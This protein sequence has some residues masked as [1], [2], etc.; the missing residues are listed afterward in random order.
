MLQSFPEDYEFVPED[1]EMYTK[2]MGR[3]IGN[4][5]PPKLAELIG[6]RILEHLEETADVPRFA[7]ADD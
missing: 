3:L 6:E 7:V 2:Q 5:V 4:A 1:E